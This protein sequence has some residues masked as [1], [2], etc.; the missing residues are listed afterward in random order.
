[1]RLRTSIAVL[2][3]APFLVMPSTAAV[4]AGGAPLDTDLVGA[5]EVPGPGDSNATGFAA[6]TLNPGRET[7]CFDLDWADIDGD[8]VAAHIHVGAAGVAGPVVVPLAGTSGPGS[9]GS[10]SGCMDVDRALVVAIRRA[11]SDYYV[12]VHSTDYPAGA[13]RGQ[14]GD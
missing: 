8:V 9:G 13:I 7:I 1:M 6:L 10:A 4:A 14:L 11:P 5:E 12:N 2:A 3:V